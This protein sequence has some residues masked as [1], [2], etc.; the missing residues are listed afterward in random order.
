MG[1]YFELTGVSKYH[2]IATLVPIFCMS[3]TYIQKYELK[4]YNER[5]KIN[6]KYTCNYKNITDLRND[7]NCII[8]EFPFFFNIFISKILSIILVLISK[9][10]T[11]ENSTSNILET[12]KTRRYHLDVN[13]KM[14]KLKAAVLIIIISLLEVIFKFENYVT[15][16]EPNY[17]ELKLGIIFLVPILSIII[18][19]KQIYLHH[20]F[21][22]VLSAIGIILICL[23]L[24]FIY[25]NEIYYTDEKLYETKKQKFGEQMRHLFF[26]IYL[27]LA[28]VLTKLLFEKSF[29]SAYSFLL[30]DGILCIVFPFI[31]ICLK[32]IDKGKEYFVDNIYGLL[33]FFNEKKIGLLF[34]SLIIFSFCYYLTNTLTLFIFSPVLL[35]STDILSPFFRWIIDLILLPIF[36]K[37]LYNIKKDN[38]NSYLVV[39]FKLIGFIIVIIAALIYNEILVLHFCNFDKNIET[40]I[41]KR[42]DRESNKNNEEFELDS[43][44]ASREESISAINMT[45]D[46]EISN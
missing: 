43:T 11:S 6:N 33:L 44:F 17:I 20:I 19:K 16:G 13:N 23:S 7:S 39:T 8:R 32:A 46:S 36:D 25:Q 30:Y 26:S 37:E 21:S 9:K 45:C 2:I 38:Q 27:S 3:T 1:K 35:V 15:Y 5:L 34:F 18:F 22:L 12:T 29:I 28:L 4:Y 10:L 31:F 41:Q 40:N 24:L 42:G 14:K